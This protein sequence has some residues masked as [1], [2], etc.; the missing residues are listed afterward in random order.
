MLKNIGFLFVFTLVKT[1][2]MELSDKT[3]D[4]FQLKVI[5]QYGSLE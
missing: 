4:F 3:G 5:N 1:V 2:E